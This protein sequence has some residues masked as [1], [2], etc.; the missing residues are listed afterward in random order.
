[1]VFLIACTGGPPAQ[2]PADG[3]ARNPSATVSPDVELRTA[4]ESYAECLEAAGIQAT[5]PRFDSANQVTS[6]PSFALTEEAIEA[7]HSCG[8]D[9]SEIAFR[10]RGE[11]AAFLEHAHAFV[12]CMRSHGIEDARVTAR[13]IRIGP[14]S[15]NAEIRAAQKQCQSFL[16]GL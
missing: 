14:G 12:D 1:L 11:E 10:P 6:W 2:G 9:L 15:S 16:E 4:L 5:P 8:Q 3:A 7:A 13:G